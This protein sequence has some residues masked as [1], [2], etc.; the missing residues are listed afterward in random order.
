M[1][2]L[3]L[4]CCLGAEPNSDHT[5]CIC[6]SHL[7]SQRVSSQC[8]FFGRRGVKGEKSLSL[9]SF[10][11]CSLCTRSGI[12]EFLSELQEQHLSLCFFIESPH[13]ILLLFSPVRWLRYFSLKKIMME[14]LFYGSLQLSK[15]LFHAP[16]NLTLKMALRSFGAQLLVSSYQGRGSDSSQKI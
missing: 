16:F 10:I 13:L 14:L 2:Q 7:N 4:N 12:P 3:P 11:P 8:P 15:P 5:L 1:P 6:V 9:C